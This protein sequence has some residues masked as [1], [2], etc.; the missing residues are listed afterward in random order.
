M[1]SPTSLDVLDASTY[2]VLASIPGLPD[3]STD[4]LVAGFNL[5]PLTR[6]VAVNTLTNTI[7]VVN[8]VTSTVSVFDGNTNTLT[9]ALTIPIPDGAVVSRPL[10]PFTQLS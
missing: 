9:G 8:S 1:T 6:P 4:F 3:Q 5:L 2:R 7:F 10:A